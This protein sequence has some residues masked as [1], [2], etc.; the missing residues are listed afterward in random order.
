MVLTM[1]IEWKKDGQVVRLIGDRHFELEGEDSVC[2]IV[3]NEMKGFQG[4]LLVELAPFY[5]RD[6]RVNDEFIKGNIGA[7]YAVP[8]SLLSLK[9]IKDRVIIF[10]DRGTASL[11]PLASWQSL[12]T[13]FFFFFFS[14]TGRLYFL[15]FIFIF[16]KCHRSQ[17]RQHGKT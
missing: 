2:E 16:C 5:Q 6:K 4:Q 17:Q 8:L 10:D 9:E 7:Y 1:D 3:L 15:L 13:S 12:S 14:H 11:V